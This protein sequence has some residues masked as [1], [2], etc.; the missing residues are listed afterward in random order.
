MFLALSSQLSLFEE[1]KCK[2]YK[3]DRNY[4]N[5]SVLIALV[6]R[7]AL[8]LCATGMPGTGKGNS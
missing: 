7:E 2:L 6:Q 8:V 3:V 1:V 4:V 5:L